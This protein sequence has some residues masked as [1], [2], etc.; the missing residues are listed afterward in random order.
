MVG[1][2]YFN[3]FNIFLVYD[4]FGISIVHYSDASDFLRHLGDIL[5]GFIRNYTYEVK[6]QPFQKF[7]SSFG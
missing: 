2:A 3:Y 4:I 6:R 7:I 5:K 1:T